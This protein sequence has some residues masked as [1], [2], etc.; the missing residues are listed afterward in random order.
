MLGNVG[1]SCIAIFVIIDN[2]THKVF[3][4]ALKVRYYLR[5]TNPMQWQ[6]LFDWKVITLD[7]IELI[8][9]AT[10]LAL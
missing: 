3:Y 10:L 6:G 2:D 8:L 7:S 4:V 1:Y 9:V 5:K